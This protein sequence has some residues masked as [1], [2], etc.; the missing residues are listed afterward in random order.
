M[1][2]R[3]A[4]FGIIEGLIII[5][6]LIVVGTLVLVAI[7]PASTKTDNQVK[8]SPT[9]ISPSIDEVKS[10][11]NALEADDETDLNQELD[12]L[13]TDLENL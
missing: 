1:F 5:G 8:T 4:D 11:Q 2:R 6:V 9:T 13:T 7:E 10:D 3:R 12:A